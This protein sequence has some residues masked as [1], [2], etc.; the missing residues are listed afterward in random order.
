MEKDKPETP[1]KAKS[2]DHPVKNFKNRISIKNLGKR[3]RWI[4][5]T[6]LV[7]LALFLAYNFFSSENKGGVRVGLLIA[8]S[9]EG[10]ELDALETFLENQEKINFQKINLSSPL[11]GLPSFSSFDLLWY[12]QDDSSKISE[13]LNN[14]RV[15]DS[16]KSYLKDG[17]NLLLTLDGMQYLKDL[18]VEPSPIATTTVELKDNGFGRKH[19]LHSYKSHPVFK[20][21]NGGAYLLNP[22]SDTTLRQTGFLG[23]R[24]PKNGRVIAV[25]W[26]YINLNEGKKL[27]VEYDFGKGKILGI[28]ACTHF[29]IPNYHHSQLE[30]FM[31]NVFDYL[32]GNIESLGN[33]WNYA[34]NRVESFNLIE[35]EVSFPEPRSW[36]EKN[37]ALRFEGAPSDNFWD[38]AGQRLLVMGKENGG[39]DEIWAHPFMALRDYRVGYRLPG[40]DRINWLEDQIENVKVTPNAFVRTYSIG[41]SHLK[42]IITVHPKEPVAVIHYD[43]NG[44]DGIRLMTQYQT[45]MRLM[46]PYSGKVNEV[47]KQSFNKDLN[48]HLFVDESSELTSVVGPSKIPEQQLSGN[49]SAFELKDGTLSGKEGEAFSVSVMNEFRL[50]HNDHLDMLVVATNESYGEATKTYRKYLQNPE[51]VYQQSQKYYEDLLS[52]KLMITTPDKDFNEAYR[53]AV[54]GADRFFVNTPGIGKSLVAGYATTANGWDGGHEVSGRPGFSWY[55]GRDGQWGGMAL[56]GYGDFEKVRDI[57]KMYIDYQ[58]PDGKIL[59]ELTTSGVVHYD[60]ADAT[61]L[62]IVLAGHYLRHSGD[63]EFIRNNWDRIEK[64]LAFCYSTDKNEDHLIDNALVGHGWV[65]RGHLFGGQ[66][67]LYLSACW[68]SALGEAAFMADA[69]GKPGEKKYREEAKTV[70]RLINEKFW[71]EQE[72]FFYHSVN[73][74]GSFIEDKTVMPAI[75]L[76]FGQID[77]AKRDPVLETL[78]REN[79]SADWGMRITGKDNPHFNPEGYHAGTVWP[80]YTGWTALAEYKNDRPLQGFVHTMNNLQVYKHWGKGFIEEVMHGLEYKPSGVC[81]HQCWSETMALQPLY[82]GMLGLEPLATEDKLSLAPAFPI[83]WKEIQVQDLRMGDQLID[84]AMRKNDTAMIYDFNKEGKGITKLEFRPHLPV[85]SLVDSVRVDGQPTGFSSRQGEDFLQ[86][87]FDFDLGQKQQV[88]IYYTGGVG[89]EPPVPTPKPGA[90]SEG[91]RVIS[92]RLEGNRYEVTVEGPANTTKEL[93]VHQ[94]YK[95]IK[96][97]EQARLVEF[98]E[99]KVRIEVGFPSDHSD[100]YI[101]KTFRL[102]FDE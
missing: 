73:A 10:A 42:E 30:G 7:L 97:V 84:F 2:F 27:M 45:N 48:A 92:A 56:N 72:A 35:D 64:A 76:Y 5:G 74:D 22:K 54:I 41:K 6:V 59:H 16:I 90:S 44:Q 101:E 63:E 87:G 67:T 37:W 52:D 102:I 12:H 83:H 25:G 77:S 24:L 19:G 4:I 51:K 57:L 68:A 17:G 20:G 60:A 79:F 65:E 69:V 9:N 93:F 75:P 49:Y 61:P 82:E 36:N 3:P 29:S 100:G 1:A 91:L 21:L 53:W 80:L 34:D 47:I 38:V 81:A 50:T 18:R 8:S 14:I 88:V 33:Y 86:L 85:A 55:F 78:A 32:A 95:E 39:I 31:K 11:S 94:G 62:F 28:G 26:S 66:S 58:S 71:D 15:N 40:N 98:M 46:W 99:S 43:Y 13:R 96:Y 70:K 23:G 89:I